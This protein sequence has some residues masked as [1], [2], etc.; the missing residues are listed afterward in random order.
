MLKYILISL[1]TIASFKVSAQDCAILINNV[2]AMDSATGL[3]TPVIKEANCEWKK[4]ELNIYNRWGNIL[5]NSKAINDVWDVTEVPIG[6]YYYTLKAMSMT[7]ENIEQ[8]GY[9]TV[10]K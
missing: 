6:T 9:I 3:Y 10:V 8:A 2:V 4:Y 5:Y 7:K 1:L